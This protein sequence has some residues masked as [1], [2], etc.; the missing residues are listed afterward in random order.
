[1]IKGGLKRKMTTKL[2]LADL[3]S[4]KSVSRPAV[5]PDGT[6]VAF[7]VEGPLQKENERY[8]NLWMVQIDKKGEPHRL[9]RGKTS[10]SAP[11]WSAD[12]RF[13][14]FLSTREYELEVKQ[15]QEK[16]K[17][18]KAVQN[19]VSGDDEPKQQIW[20]FDMEAGGEP[21]QLTAREE[22]VEEFCWSPEG[23]EL[24]FS[25]RDP[26]KAQIGYLKSIR[27]KGKKK[28]KG[29][30]VI[31]RIQHKHDGQGFLDDVRTHLFIVE[32][33][34]RATRALTSGPC[35]ET[36]PRWSPNGKSI[37]FVSNRTGD[38][39]NNQR[40]DL[41]SISAA[42]SLFK[43]L[44]FGD[45]NA[46][47]PR[48]SPDSKH[49]AFVSSISEP[50]NAYRLQHVLVVSAEGVEDVEDIS[51]CVGKGWASIGGVVPDEVDG[52][53]VANG[54]VYPVPVKQTPVRILTEQLDRPVVGSPVWLNSDELLVLMG[55]RGQTRLVKASLSGE[56]AFLFPV[57]ERMCTLTALDYAHGMM[58]IGL[59]RPSTGADLFALRIEALGTGG[60][61][62]DAVQLTRFNRK[63][64]NR[65]D[66]AVYRRIE[67]ANSD[68]ETVE[69][70]VALPPRWKEK[71]APL[72]I[73]IHGGPM[74]YDEPSF[75][76]D[77]Q[78]W[79]ALGYVVLMVNYRGS[80]SYGEEFCA[81]IRGS[82]GPR[83]H[84]DLICGVNALIERGWAD[85]Q[86]LFCTG[87]SQ[88]GIMT[89]WAVGQTDIFRAAASEHGMWDYVAAFGTDDCHLWW[90]DDVG[91]PWQNEDQYRRIS[92][93]SGAAEINTPLL[94]MAGEHD[95]RCPLAQSEQLYITLKK[96][97]IPARLV[98]YQGEHH[99]ISKPKRAID[100]IRRISQWF[101]DHGGRPFDDDSA[102]GY[103]DQSD[104]KE[105]VS[106]KV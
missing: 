101:A 56:G 105:G 79:A 63:V 93:L 18:E 4:L 97:G 98:I 90:Q 82:W 67:F 65:V 85:P 31:D 32:Q 49:V 89:N 22:G 75:R 12:G 19:E 33:Q 24:V 102:E 41:W 37:V 35:D 87:F 57:D 42:G 55:D 99:A 54:R 104:R 80:I 62:K 9:T 72:I 25:S 23:S 29:P 77:T 15:G 10:D 61:D 51:K 64:F 5:S 40:F 81:V 95:W 83:E 44:T 14:A 11:A 13:L 71:M 60:E 91:V 26:D 69:A 6:R 68:G 21:R 70:L 96:R 45:L 46:H 100:R 106:P 39:D 78:Y 20:V 84:D 8:Q 88:G 38:A 1:M 86:R 103:P 94:I 36:A 16:A 28:D 59:N 58:V 3:Y 53:P 76:F 74:A 43:R 66:T 52:D 47:S 50:E 73:D 7:I 48:W 17:E 92:P 30:L 34:S 27:G 2:C